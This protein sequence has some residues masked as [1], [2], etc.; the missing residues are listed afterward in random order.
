[1]ERSIEESIKNRNYIDN[2]RNA[3]K[4][5]P[6]IIDLVESDIEYGL[7]EEQTRL[8]LKRN[9]KLPQM[10]M[11]SQCLRKGANEAFVELLTKY[12]MSGHQIQVAIEFLEKGISVEN[13]EAVVANGEKPAVMRKSFEQML[14]KASQVRSSAETAPEYV[15][16]LVKQI[17]EAVAKIQYQEER[18]D[19]LNRK[20]KVFENAK[21]DE[22]VHAGLVKKLEDTEAELNSQQDQ[23][24][25]ANATIARLREQIDEKKKEMERMQNRIDT[26]EDKL[27]EKAAT[28]SD[29]GKAEKELEKQQEQEKQT[30]MEEKPITDRPYHIPVYYQLP[31]VDSNGRVVQHVQIE[32]TVRKGNQRAFSSLLGKLGF[33]KKSRQDIVKLLASGDLVP[34]QLVQIRSA[35][36]K[37]LTEGQLIELINNNISA[38]KM[39]EIIDIAVLENSLDY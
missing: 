31:V 33:M 8:Y 18:Y 28:K 3:A 20:L 5:S 13:I 21:K 38:E 24:N 37:G 36:E 19:E 12:D 6:E 27:L 29:E 25:R 10:K 1:M 35:I 22:E 9:I 2:L 11:M 4:Y 39:K 7:T 15:Q 30:V 32:R 34:A 23:L 26:L 17:E 14:E 16:G